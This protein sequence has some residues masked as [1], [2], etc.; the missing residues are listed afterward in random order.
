M[1]ILFPLLC[2]LPILSSGCTFGPEFHL[3]LPDKGAA[4]TI[5]EYPEPEDA[6]HEDSRT[7]DLRSDDADRI[8][9]TAVR[10]Q[11]HA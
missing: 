9:R 5:I 4:D 3:H 11:G 8:A 10:V 7:Q 2:C 6:D 1:G